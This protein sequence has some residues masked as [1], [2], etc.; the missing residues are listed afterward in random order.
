MNQHIS[1]A[2][3]MRSTRPA[4]RAQPLLTAE[5]ML[6]WL[7][8]ARTGERVEYFRG[9]YLNDAISFYPWRSVEERDI[10]RRLMAQARECAERGR[11]H[12][13]QKR[14]GPGD[15]SYIAVRAD[16]GHG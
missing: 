12:L 2:E 4:F 8:S 15:Y 9:D 11:C 6:Q 16:V 1:T 5:E 14:H 10:A 7:G 3:A 13:F